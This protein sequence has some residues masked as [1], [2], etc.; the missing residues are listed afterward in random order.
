MASL[1][2]KVVGAILPRSVKSFI[3]NT[4]VNNRKFMLRIA[5]KMFFSNRMRMGLYRWL[6]LKADEGSI[7][8]CGN[9]INDC[10]NISLGRN[11]ILGPCNVLLAQGGIEI[12]ENVNISGFC[13]I[14]SQE[15][16]IH[17]PGL[18][19]TLAPVIIED[20]AW[21]ATGVTIL[22][23]VRIGKG[24]IIAAGSIV[25]KNVEAFA[26]MAGNPARKIAERNSELAYTTHDD[27]GLKWL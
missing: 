22:P 12:G 19:T 18:R 5:R 17:D 1:V 4:T 26:V 10:I 11:S 6:G 3:G 9:K 15:H 24:A 27:R 7:I 25:T 20:Y 16:D 8:W 14:I 2:R 23:G 13:F 21:I